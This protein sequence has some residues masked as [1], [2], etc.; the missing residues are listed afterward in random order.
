MSSAITSKDFAR[1]SQQ[2]KMAAAQPAPPSRSF[3]SWAE[4]TYRCIRRISQATTA[5]VW[6]VR[7]VGDGTRLHVLKEIHAVAEQP[8]D[9]EEWPREVALLTGQKHPFILPVVEMLRDDATGQVGMVTEYCDQGDLHSLL[10]ELRRRNE[11]VPE[12]QVLSWLA[13]LCL[14]LSHLHRQRILHRDVKTSNI[15]VTADRT[16]KLGDFGL[17][18]ALQAQ[19]EAVVTRVGS[20]FYMSP[21]ICRNQPYGSESDVW[22]L[23]CV[24]Y[25]II[26]LSPAFYADS[27]VLVLQRIC[28]AQYDAPPT[29]ACS[30]G[31]RE[32]LGEMLQ[33]EPSARPS[34]QMVLQHPALRPVLQQLEPPAPPPAAFRERL[35][36]DSSEVEVM[37][38]AVSAAAAREAEEARAA[39]QERLKDGG[40]GGL[41]LLGLS[42]LAERGLSLL[43]FSFATPLGRQSE[44]SQR[45]APAPEPTASAHG[46]AAGA[47]AAL[48]V[49]SMHNQLAARLGAPT[50]AR[51]LTLAED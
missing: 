7:R 42:L 9:S 6:L 33:L 39:E 15:F 14:A 50:L 3:P 23:G 30:D 49:R 21:E 18:R 51:A 16:L 12:A 17:A 48:A 10:I 27:M 45:H 5:T 40:V 22:S 37:R 36:S 32:L 19:Q 29:G 28:A 20:P 4:P 24:L 26:C 31:V 13:Q 1:F 25:E 43:G 34:A 11:R 41:S 35:A 44:V 46:V 2:K 38:A 47:D 8:A